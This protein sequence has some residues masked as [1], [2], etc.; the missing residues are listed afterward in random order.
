MPS[1]GCK[2]ICYLNNM[3]GGKENDNYIGPI[4]AKPLVSSAGYIIGQ[5]CHFSFILAGCAKD[6]GNML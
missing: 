4:L 6:S 5:S 2:Y 3:D 1:G